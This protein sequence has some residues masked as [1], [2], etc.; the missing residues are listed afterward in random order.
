MAV[1]SA[2]YAQSNEIEE[3]VVTAE[4]REQSLQD[5]PVAVSAFT[6]ERRD[7]VGINSVQDLTNFTPGLAYSTNNDRIALRGIGRFTNNRSSEGGVAMYSDGFYTS[8][9]TAFAQS[10]L[11]IERTEAL[12]GPQGTLY[13]RNAIGGALNITSKRPTE[14]LYAEVR[15]GYGNYDAKFGEGAISGPLFGTVRGRLAGSYNH[16]GK[17]IYE[18]LNPNGKD[19]GGRGAQWTIEGQL[20][21]SLADEKLEWWAKASTTEWHTLGRGP[22]GRTTATYG[23]RDTINSLQAALTPNAANRGVT[24]PLLPGNTCQLCFDTDDGNYINLES[25]TYTLNATLHLDKVDVKYIGGMTYYDYRLQT[26]LD[27]TSRQAPFLL[28]IPA[29]AANTALIPGQTTNALYFPRQH[30]QYEEEVWWF[31]NELNFTSTGD[32]PFQWLI[33][34]YQFREG[35]NYTL[36]DAR[37]PDDA[38]FERPTTQ[39]GVAVAPN[40]DRRYAYGSSE[41]VSESYGT[42]GQF[43]WQAT[44]QLKF[45]AGIRYTYDRKRSF[46]SARLFCLYT[47]SCPISTLTGRPV[48]ITDAAAPGVSTDPSIYLAAYTDPTT[49][50]RHRGLKNSWSAVTGTLGVDWKPDADTLAYAKYTRGYKAGGFN[51]GTTTLTPNVTTGK[52]TIDAYE[53]G[54]KKTLGGRLQVNGSAF[55]YDYQDIQVPISGLDPVTSLS[56]TRFFNMPK[57]RILGLELESIW[58]PIENLQILANYSYLN[59]ELRKACCFQDPDDPRGQLPGVVLSGNTAAALSPTTATGALNTTALNQDL[60]GNPLPSST[61]HR[62]TINTNYTWEFEP[63]NVT[64]SATYV[65]RAATYYSIFTDYFNKAKSFGQTDLRVLFNDKDDKWTAIGYV[66]NAFD[67]RGSAGTNGTRIPSFLPGQPNYG[68]VNQTYSYVPPRTYGVELQ[69][70]F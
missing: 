24:N 63:G 48:D 53:V 50:F 41:N 17:G 59:A 34:L 52:E 27:G 18:N 22:G 49:G 2:A 64:L 16:T 55:Y 21:G 15:A 47:A 62:V 26:D 10:T 45:T 3:L 54:L 37:F 61:P 66:K 6:D 11:F 8:S 20:E 65:W 33:G 7:L 14:D 44:D 42:F 19:E 43:D 9:V 38:R 32:G 31:S 58:Q 40:L 36:S 13:G 12:R 5:V 35:S 69:Y 29:R 70:R 56:V 39:T 25:N 23:L 68:F 51:S 57:A 67:T 1:S 60:K 46:E 28:P 30:N 4:K